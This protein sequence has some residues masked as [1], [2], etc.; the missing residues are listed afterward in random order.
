MIIQIYF[1]FLVTSTITPENWWESGK[2]KMDRGRDR[3]FAPTKR[4][5]ISVTGA[6]PSPAGKNAL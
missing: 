6:D 5:S 1:L 4:V 2:I 3:E